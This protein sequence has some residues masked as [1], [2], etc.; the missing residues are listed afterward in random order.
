MRCKKIPVTGLGDSIRGFC[1]TRQPGA[2][3]KPFDSFNLADHVGDDHAHV[4]INRQHLAQCLPQAPVWVKQVH[5]TRVLDATTID[6]TTDF[7]ADALVTTQAGQV[8]AILTADCMPVVM[9]DD[10]HR[11]LGLAHAGWRGLAGGVLSATV[12]AMQ[13]HVGGMGSW[14]AWIGPCIGPRAFEVGEEVRETFLQIDAGFSQY[15]VRDVAPHKWRCNMPGIARDMLSG[16]GAQAVDWCGLCT[17]DDPEQ[18]FFSYRRQ[19]Q[20]GRMATVAWIEA[21]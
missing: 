11:V 9:A 18:R 20:T 1:T 2:S 12:A 16:L 19:G 8:L 21:A 13:A 17:V 10:A 6:Q 5:G 4:E 3:A 14:R 7:E 15:F